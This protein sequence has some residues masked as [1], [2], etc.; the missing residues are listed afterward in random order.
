MPRYFFHISGALEFQDDQGTE[1]G[2]VE[3]ARI[4]AVRFAG[5]LLFSEPKHLLSRS[6]WVVT[7][8][9]GKDAL[10]EIKVEAGSCHSER[11][12]SDVGA[13]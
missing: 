5:E 11:Q 8:T 9:D 10:F 4:E 6:H 2:D 13:G 12:D 3:R 1:F 7:M